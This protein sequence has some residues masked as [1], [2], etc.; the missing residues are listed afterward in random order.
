[1]CVCVTVLCRNNRV[2]VCSY[3]GVIA[4]DSAEQSTA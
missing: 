1:M 2:S 3:V 4:K